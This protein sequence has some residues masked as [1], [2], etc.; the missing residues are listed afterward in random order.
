[1]RIREDGVLMVRV[2]LPNRAI[3]C[4]I[5]PDQHRTEV[6]WTTHKQVHQGISK[7]LKKL[8]LDWYWPGM[9]ADIRRQLKTCE[10]CQVAKHG[11]LATTQGRRRL[12][13]GRPWQRVAVDLVGPMPVTEKGESMDPGVNRPFH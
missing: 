4:A 12:F 9:T 7:T 3:E 8:Q 5:C 1:M 10:V 11:G 13:A 6:I 2:L